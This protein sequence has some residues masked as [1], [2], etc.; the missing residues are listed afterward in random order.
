M[1]VSCWIVVLTLAMEFMVASS[2]VP[3]ASPNKI[4]EPRPTDTTGVSR[5]S[6]LDLLHIADVEDLPDDDKMAGN[7]GS[8]LAIF[9]KAFEE[10]ETAPGLEQASLE[11]VSREKSRPLGRMELDYAGAGVPA[12][13]S[14]MTDDDMRATTDELLYD[15]SVK[16]FLKRRAAKDPNWL[17]WTS[18]GCTGSLDKPFGWPFRQACF[19][20]DFGIRNYRLQKRSG[21]AVKDDLDRLFLY[22][23]RDV[24]ARTAKSLTRP[25]CNILAGIYYAGARHFGRRFQ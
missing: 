21:R 20:R 19:R 16:D 23:T 13:P 8:V 2:P 17:L 22:D 1:F 15:M 14:N 12:R 7:I 5:D 24:C 3:G 6:L 9:A 18:D 10:H 4:S 11:E 25:S